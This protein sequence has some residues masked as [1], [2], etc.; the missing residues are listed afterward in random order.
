MGRDL[1]GVYC[2]TP[3]SI[4]GQG[5]ALRNEHGA[6]SSVDSLVAEIKEVLDGMPPSRRTAI[7]RELYSF[8]NTF[9]SA[10]IKMPKES[11]SHD[12]TYGRHY[13]TVL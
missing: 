6:M 9:P 10:E 3:F 1:R 11:S 12:S 4:A 7:L 2:A 13:G 5:T 8:H